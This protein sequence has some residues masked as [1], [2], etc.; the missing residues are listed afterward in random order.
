M[1]VPPSLPNSTC[2]SDKEPN[3]T[4]DVSCTF[5]LNP[6][7][8]FLSSSIYF[9]VVKLP[10][11]TK[12]SSRTIYIIR[13]FIFPTGSQKTLVQAPLPGTSGTHH[14]TLH[15]CILHSTIYLSSEQLYMQSLSWCHCMQLTL[16]SCPPLYRLKKKQRTKSYI[17]V[18]VLEL[19]SIYLKTL[20]L[21]ITK[22]LTYILPILVFQNQKW[23]KPARS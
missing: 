4:Y 6:S 15:V 23:G 13:V 11:L 19:P 12:R 7:T 22:A 1:I 14:L 16:F 5:I 9:Y 10:D 8:P 21:T 20:V 3:A 17:I 2:C 18:W